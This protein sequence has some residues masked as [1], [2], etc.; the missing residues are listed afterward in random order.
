[1]NPRAT[2]IAE[3]GIR[4]HRRVPANQ[5]IVHTVDAV[6]AGRRNNPPDAKAGIRP[7]AVYN[8]IH[9]QELPELFIDFIC[10]L[11]GKS[12]STTGAGSEGA[13]T[14]GPFN[15]LN[16]TADLNNA[17]L[18]YILTGYNG[19]TTAAGY[20][21]PKYR[22]DHDIS[23]LIPEVWCRLNDQERSADFLIQTG[24]L[25]PLKDFQYKGTNI[26]ASRLGYRITEKFVRLYFGRMF[27]S[28][29]ALF[30]EEML[31]GWHDE[32]CGSPKTGCR[33]LLGRWLSECRHSS[34]QSADLHYGYGYL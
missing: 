32:H 20:V 16:P 33:I 3:M 11:T 2:Y 18:S 14:K 8:P 29:T 4:L 15:A 28:P 5:K 22:V 13:L 9:Y 7:I 21:G 10:S 24:C 25:E 19:F 17:L 27:D 26:P 23:L 34:A 31:R 30:N 12:P 6:L 1:M